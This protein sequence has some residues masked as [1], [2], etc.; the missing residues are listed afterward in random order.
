MADIKEVRLL[1]KTIQIEVNHFAK[2]ANGSVMVS[3]GDTQV[4]VSV[5]AASQAKDG[6]DFFPLTVDYIE[7]F[8]SAGRIPGGYIKRES[9][10]SEREVLTA[11]CIDRPLRPSFH[12]KY[13][14]DTFVT[15]YVVSYDPQHHPAPLA[16]FGASCALMISDIPFNGPIASLRVGIDPKTGEFCLDPSEDESGDLDLTLSASPKAILM[17]EAGA[18]FLS[19]EKMLEAITWGHE[20]M[21]PLFD[22]QLQLQKEVGKAKMQVNA[23]SNEE[24]VQS[25]Q[26]KY[27]TTIDEYLRI[28]VKADRYG[29]LNEL[30]KEIN[31]SL[32]PDGSTDKKLKLY[33]AYDE[34]KS[35]YM[36][37]MI[38]KDKVRIDGRGLKDIRP[39]TCELGVLRKT[40]GSA[41]FTRGETQVLGVVTLGAQDDGQRSD[42]INDA[43]GRKRFM[44]HYNFPPLSVGEA[45]PLRP[46]GRREIGHG[47]LA[48]RAL[49]R[50]MPPIEEFGYAIRL[51]GEV[52]ESNGS[53]SMATVCAGSMA[54]LNA[55]V[56]LRS[57][58]S[59]IA[60]GLILEPSGEYAILSDILGD[61]DHLGDMDFKVCGNESGISALQMDIKVSGLSTEI[62]RAALDQA[63]EGRSFILQKMTQTIDKPAP[64]SDNAPRIFTI[65]IKTDRIKDLIGP[66]G[67]N[68]KKIVAETQVKIDIED[69]G[70]VNIVAPTIEIAE[71]AKQLIRDLTE[72]PEPGSMFL[73]TVKKVTDF[74]CFVEI[75][76][77][78][79]GLVHISQLDNKRIENIHDH[80]KEGQEMM[81]KLLEV[82]KMG[83][84]KLSRKEAMDGATL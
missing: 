58:V 32:N 35:R 61:E 55:G 47:M 26:A 2:Q 18:N 16:A 66:G 74:G 3:C 28:K 46:P 41:L 37:S 80:V 67:K 51:V 52:L 65:Q 79:E 69:S 38:L 1:N 64:L 84:L 13:M 77:G 17:V 49:Q 24:L 11:R 5:C 6:Q 12:E 21:K 7:K 54:M 25:L 42:T 45:R 56:P 31:S 83:R 19:E 63:K 60:M 44:L 71:K 50:V 9:K 72:D 40:H 68:I 70:K 33:A 27:G 82:D 39:I 43:D 14:N 4:L 20:Q 76:P 73:G 81:V 57:S 48:E 62:L 75:K 29:S 34:L 10:P 36:R 23:E 59:G 15:A 53:S 78:V 30:F 8:Y 22:I